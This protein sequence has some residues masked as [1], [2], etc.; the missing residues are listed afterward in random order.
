VVAELIRA[1]EAACAEGQTE[2]AEK[3]ARAALLLD[4]TCFSKKR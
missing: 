1:Y 2:E 3:L 4:P